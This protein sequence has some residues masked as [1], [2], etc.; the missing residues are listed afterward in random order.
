MVSEVVDVLPSVPPQGAP[1]LH[2]PV[3]SGADACSTRAASSQRPKAKPTTAE[4]VEAA[5]IH[6]LLLKT[7]LVPKSKQVGLTHHEISRSLTH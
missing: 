1:T 6:N 7:T 5:V 3:S 4:M 2:T